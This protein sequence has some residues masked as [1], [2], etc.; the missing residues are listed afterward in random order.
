MI[1]S[2]D[3]ILQEELNNLTRVLLDCAYPLHLIIKNKKKPWSTTAII[4]YPNEHHRQKP[5]FSP[6]QL[7]SQTLA[8]Y[9]GQLYIRISTIMPITP[10]S[11]PFDHPKPY[12]PI[13]NPAAFITILSTLHKHMAPHSRIPNTTTH[14]HLHTPIQT[15][16]QWYTH[17][18]ITTVV[19]LVSSSIPS[20]RN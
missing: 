7:L 2:E 14:T 15:Y 9:S 18:D 10:Y 16:R 13:P 1:I 3:L 11:P 19:T 4:C 17:G 5:T 20:T 8:N 12:Q 6:F